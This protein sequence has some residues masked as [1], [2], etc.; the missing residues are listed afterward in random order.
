VSIFDRHGKKL[1]ESTDPEQ[2]WEGT[3]NGYA[4]PS[5]DY[6]YIINIDDIRAIF[7]GHF[8]LIR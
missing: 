4:L 3:Y 7:T 2:E 1:F 5:E 8:T 6:W